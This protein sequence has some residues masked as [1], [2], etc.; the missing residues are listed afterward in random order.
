MRGF[1]AGSLWRARYVVGLIVLGVSEVLVR[2][3]IRHNV[4]QVRDEEQSG[5][6]AELPPAAAMD[7]RELAQRDHSAVGLPHGH[8]HRPL[9]RAR[10]ARAGRSFPQVAAA[11]RVRR[12]DFRVFVM[13][14]GVFGSF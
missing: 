9:R 10:R 2:L 13:G 4:D 3:W 14:F 12:F 6:G 11:V 1:G 5:E 8:A 7:S